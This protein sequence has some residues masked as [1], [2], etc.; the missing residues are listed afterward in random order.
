MR[1]SIR[2]GNLRPMSIA[3]RLDE[4]PAIVAL[5]NAPVSD[6]P[7]TPDEVATLEAAQKNPALVSHEDVVAALDANKPSN[8]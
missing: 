5:R 8:P 7:L 2:S 3:R 6:I 1:A 4:H